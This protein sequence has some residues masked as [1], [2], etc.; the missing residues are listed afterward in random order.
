MENFEV[1]SSAQ[2]KICKIQ[3]SNPGHYQKI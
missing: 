2:H 1:F 3:S